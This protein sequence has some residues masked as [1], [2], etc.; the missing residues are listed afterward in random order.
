MTTQTKNNSSPSDRSSARIIS[1]AN[2]K[3]GVGKTTITALLA[4]ILGST[5]QKKVLVID[6]DLQATIAMTRVADYEK[7]DGNF[8]FPYEI[9]SIEETD[10]LH[11]LVQEH[12]GLVDF[13]FIDAPRLTN[14]DDIIKDA[15][16]I[17][18]P[19]DSILIPTQSSSFSTDSMFQFLPVIKEIEKQ[20]TDLDLDFYFYAFLNQSRST[21][22]DKEVLELMKQSEE[23]PFFET[24]LSMLEVFVIKDSYTSIFDKKGGKEKFEPFFKEFIEKFKIEL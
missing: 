15:I 17:F 21:N 16:N 9:I 19:C 6:A 18:A 20:R 14:K 11:E 8:V 4:N 3:G 5:Y 24:P 10:T 12:Q 23:V 7:K 13:I 1:V 2:Q 22:N